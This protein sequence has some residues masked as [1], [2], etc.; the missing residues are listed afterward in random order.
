MSASRIGCRLAE[1]G[2]WF[3]ERGVPLDLSMMSPPTMLLW[4]LRVSTERHLGLEVAELFLPPPSTPTTAASDQATEALP[5][6]A[7]QSLS[8][9]P[10]GSSSHPTVFVPPLPTPCHGEESVL[11]QVRSGDPLPLLDSPSWTPANLWQRRPCT[12]DV[13]MVRRSLSKSGKGSLTAELE[14]RYK[15]IVCDAVWTKARLIEADYLLDSDK[16]DL[17]GQ[18]TDTLHHRFWLCSHPQ[19]VVLRSSVTTPQ[20]RREAIAAGPHCMWH[21][22]G[23]PF[24]VSDL[25][26]G[27]SPYPLARF[28]KDD[29][30]VTGSEWRF[31]RWVL[32]QRQAL[33]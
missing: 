30:D 29:V 27:P 13:W 32:H 1:P 2:L 23:I 8:A 10:L 11:H 31:P 6:P 9:T 17:C 24:F 7:V 3:T 33:L 5:T 4:H 28:F 15:A 25:A 20:L 14:G 16:C 19:A 21:S 22:R 26:V 18:D 12:A